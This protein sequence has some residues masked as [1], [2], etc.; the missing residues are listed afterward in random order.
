MTIENDILYIFRQFTIDGIIHV[1][2]SELDLVKKWFELGVS[3]SQIDTA[4]KKLASESKIQ[5][6]KI[7]RFPWPV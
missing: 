6:E 1:T 2:E 3:E 7:T 4:I 5:I